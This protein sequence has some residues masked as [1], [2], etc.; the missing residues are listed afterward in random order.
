M[1]MESGFTLRGT[2]TDEKGEPIAGATAVWR[3]AYGLTNLVR[4]KTGADGRFLFEHRPPGIALI[5]AEV[6]GLAM[7]VKQVWLGPPDP[8]TR[9]P[10][11]PIGPLFPTGIKQPAEDALIAPTPPAGMVFASD[12]TQIAKDGPCKPALVFRLGPGRTIQGRVVDTRGR[13]IAGA[14]VT[15][16]FMGAPTWS[17]TASRPTPMAASSG[18]TRRS[19]SASCE[20]TIPRRAW[21]SGASARVREGQIVVTMPA[22]FRLR[23]K[24][25]DAETG[26]PIDRFRLTERFVWTHDFAPEDDDSPP[27][28]PLDRDHTVVGGRY[29]VRF[30]RLSTSVERRRIGSVDGSHRGRGIRSSD[31]TKVRGAGGRADL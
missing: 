20:W 14:S 21:W 27:D 4:V 24:V 8:N 19:K 28:R 18:L 25:V 31:L 11:M 1:V 3:A 7:G 26:R 2:V 23:G 30:P 6:P 12:A 15:P 10:M 16:E 5:S 29:E 17:A 9:L 22:P 13:P